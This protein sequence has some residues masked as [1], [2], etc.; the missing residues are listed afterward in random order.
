E[1]AN[2][3]S[4][5]SVEIIKIL[6][7]QGQMATINDVIDADTAQLI[8]EELGHTVKRVAE[9]D[10][11]EGVFDTAD[12]RATLAPRAPVVTVMGHV[13]HG[14]TSLLDAIRSTNVVSGEAGG[15]TQHIGAYQV[16]SP[17]N[18]KITFIDTPGHAAF[19]AMRARGAKV[20][21]IVVL[22]VAADDGVMPQTIEAINHAKAAKVPMIV[23]INKIDKADA[24]PMRVRTDLLQHEVQVESMGGDVVDVELSA[25]KKT[26][27]DKLLEMIGLQAEILDLKA[28]PERAA[29]GTVIEAKLDRGRGAVA[30]VLVQRGTLHVGDIIVAGA[31]WGRAR[32]LVSDTGDAVRDAGPSVPV[33]VLGFAGTPD[34]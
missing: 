8:A 30:T 18:G 11:E 2:R 24:N 10:V 17:Q 27:I 16:D 5:R 29:E 9:A 1:L 33:E 20:T 4:E 28:N 34:A 25:T 12:D 19:T 7:K 23:A 13:D 15:I 31:E 21:D 3:M 26:N 6:M 22:V 32:A 14:K